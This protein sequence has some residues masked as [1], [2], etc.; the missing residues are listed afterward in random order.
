MTG[1]E[2]RRTTDN[3]QG[4]RRAAARRGITLTE[5]LIA[6]MIL[7]IGLVS[8]A[9]LFPIGLA[10]L[11]DASRYSRS[12][13]LSQSGATDMSA[14]GLLF[15]RSFGVADFLNTNYYPFWYATPAGGANPAQYD[16]F[17]QDTQFYGGLAADYT[18]TPPTYFGATS[19]FVWV[20]A[21]NNQHTL[22]TGSGLPFAYDPLWRHQTMDPTNPNSPLNRGV[23]L[24]PLNSAGRNIPEARFGAGTDGQ[25]PG[26]FIPFEPDGSPP[27]AWGLQRL[28]NFNR[29]TA[30]NGLGQTVPL[31]PADNAVP[32][33]FV[34]PEDIVL[35]DPSGTSYTI[36]GVS[37]A[38]GGI[39]VVRPSPIIPDLN[40][41]GGSTTNDWRYSW[42]FTGL[43]TNVPPIQNQTS[44]GATFEG[45]I[46]VFENRPF[47]IS[48]VTSP[49]GP[50]TWQIDGETVVEAVWGYSTSVVPQG[51]PG[52]GSGADRTVV[53]RWPAVMPD[54]V[55][56]AGNWIADI[57]YERNQSLV[58]SRFLSWNAQVPPYVGLPNPINNGEW[59]NL[60]AQ[61][62][63]WYQVQRVTPP[64]A[65]VGQYAFPNDPANYRYMV[66]TVNSSLQARTILN[67]NGQPMFR[68]AA[69]ICPTV[70]NVIP[71][72]FTTIAVQ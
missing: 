36:D 60:P 59:D 50:V 13:Y 34:S 7:G 29:A 15:K 25:A 14:R 63:F 28:T 27:S 48:Q 41:S 47:G 64:A 33:I 37:P 52:Y 43:Q 6:I 40:T 57:T 55:V 32:S 39:P 38:N 1:S 31:F 70:V 22:N 12:A 45:N 11:R 56:K 24:D 8:L 16:P 49:L 54:P 23:Y 44:L 20:D 3:G 51:G 2:L 46:V 9:A 35:Q 62:C 5:I 26:T 71:Q 42:M 4:T 17:T 19:S 10:R 65:A 72:T 21:N 69:L 66:V 67:G 61:R 68:N 53:L 18:T 30:I 58:L